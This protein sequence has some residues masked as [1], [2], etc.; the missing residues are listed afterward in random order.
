[1]SCGL[2]LTRAACS[3]S[4]AAA[5]ASVTRPSSPRARTA[6]R[7]CRI[8]ASPLPPA[9]AAPASRRAAAEAVGE[10]FQRE[11]PPG[12]RRDELRRGGELVVGRRPR[13]R[14]GRRRSRWRRRRPRRRTPRP[15][16]AA[17]CRRRARLRRRRRW[18]RS[19]GPRSASRRTRRAGRR[20]RRGRPARGPPPECRARSHRARAAGAGATRRG[21]PSRRSMPAPATAIRGS[22]AACAARS[23]TSSAAPRRPASTSV[24]TSASSSAAAGS[25]RS[26]ASSQS[27]ATPGACRRTPAAAAR[28]VAAAST[29]PGAAAWARC[30]AR[31]ANGAPAR[32]SSRAAAAWPASRAP[33]PS[34]SCTAVRTTGWRK[35]KRRGSSVPRMS[36]RCSI[37]SRASSPA[38][39]SSAAIRVAR[40]SSNGSPATAAAWTR[41]R[42]SPGSDSTST[43]TAATM[44]PGTACVPPSRA[45]SR[46][47]QRVA[48][49]LR[50][51]PVALARRRHA[52]QQ[53]L[54]GDALQ[55]AQVERDE[56]HR[57][58]GALRRE[59]ALGRRARPQ[60]ERHEQGVGRRAAHEMLEQL[61]RRGVGPVDVVDEQQERPAAGDQRQQ[62]AERSMQAPA[63]GDRV[64]RR[65]GHTQS[66]EDLGEEVD[67]VRSEPLQRTDVR[68]GSVERVDHR[69]QRDVVLELGRAALEHDEALRRGALAQ[70]GQQ[71]RL[72]DARLATG[73]EQAPLAARDGVE[74]PRDRL[75]LRIAA[76]Q[77]VPRHRLRLVGGFPR[78]WRRPRLG[79]SISTDRRLHRRPSCPAAPPPCQRQRDRLARGR[80]RALRRRR[81]DVPDPLAAR[82]PLRGGLPGR[83]RA[84]GRLRPRA[85]APL[86]AGFAALAA[87]IGVDD[88][89]FHATA[90]PDVAFVEEHMSAE[91]HDGGRY[92]NDL[93]MRVTFRDG[94]IA[95]I[96]EYY[97]E[98][99]HEDLLRRL[100][101]GC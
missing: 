72:A 101:I 64:A 19:A 41:A 69:H 61:A 44:P 79:P 84:L 39:P 34:V 21:G 12:H 31:T 50:E 28:S 57:I 8:D 22:W 18:A 83:R 20:R 92:E 24:P 30:C 35:A 53:R 89:R 36:P 58:A 46:Q 3:T 68:E 85:H 38:G 66:R 62:L 96:F 26:A 97:G 13:R 60:A 100:G 32:A 27:A 49:R 59:Q 25:A 73:E 16:R 54:G 63:L 94:L 37:T 29:S 88:V 33:A 90:D 80:R 51:E 76:E 23:T 9:R 47:Q 78:C 5:A 15:P 42:A 48:A 2:A 45:S 43:R 56:A 82:W 77:A 7:S 14:P 17:S 55:R 70:L 65:H 71:P 10:A 99:A 40:S 6:A 1:M 87:W 75:E 52:G 93:C 98:R 91:L 11:Q 74:R 86:F 67:A 81:R 95:S 4:S